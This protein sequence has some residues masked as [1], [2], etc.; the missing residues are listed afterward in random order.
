MDRK[1]LTVVEL[2]FGIVGGVALLLIISFLLYT[3]NVS[4]K[5]GEKLLELKR[6]ASF[7][8][9]FIQKKLRGNSPDNVEITKQ[10]K[11][12]IINPSQ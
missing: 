6:E 11:K 10:G 3:S 12:L 5:K 7:G 9:R 2:I 8:L 1:G 4:F